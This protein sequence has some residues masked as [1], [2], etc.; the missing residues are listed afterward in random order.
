[1]TIG[2]FLFG[3][4]CGVT[5]PFIVHDNIYY[6]IAISFLT[7]HLKFAAEKRKRNPDK[8]I[9]V[10][11]LDFY[12]KDIGKSFLFFWLIIGPT[13]YKT[14]YTKEN[15]FDMVDESDAKIAEELFSKNDSFADLLTKIKTKEQ[16]NEQAKEQAKGQ[17]R[18]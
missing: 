13:L 17:V 1:M 9:P 6:A 7:P 18:A 11:H 3:M 14:Y 5:I 4:G 8:A 12:L 10:Q 16:T 2:R 15:M